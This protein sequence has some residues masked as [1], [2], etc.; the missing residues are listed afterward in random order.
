MIRSTV[1]MCWK[2]QD[3]KLIS[4]ST[5]RSRHLVRRPVLIR[6]LVD[7]LEHL[8]DAGVMLI[9]LG[10]VA[11]D[12]L[13]RHAMADAIEVA[14]E[15]V[16]EARLLERVLELAVVLEVMA[17]AVTAARGPCCRA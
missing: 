5:S 17:E 4:M 2:R 12:A 15:L 8:D 3:W 1:F 6:V 10:P 11:L 9:R 7:D 13:R 14:Q 16:V